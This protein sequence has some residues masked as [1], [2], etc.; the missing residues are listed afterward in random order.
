VRGGSTITG[1]SPGLFICFNRV[2]ASATV[3]PST[4][5]TRRSTTGSTAGAGRVSGTTSSRP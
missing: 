1:S 2:R 3:P 5:R 4:G